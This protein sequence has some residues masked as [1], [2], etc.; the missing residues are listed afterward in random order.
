[1]LRGAARARLWHVA[2]MAFTTGQ[3]QGGVLAMR[4]TDIESDHT[5]SSS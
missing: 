3:R 4:R 2:A 1:V 5:R